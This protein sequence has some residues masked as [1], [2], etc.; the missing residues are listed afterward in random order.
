LKKNSYEIGGIFAPQPSEM[1]GNIHCLSDPN[2]RVLGYISASVV[3]SKRIF[4][5]GKELMM[6]R[7]PFTCSF[8]DVPGSPG[9]VF[10]N[11]DRYTIG[12]RVA[13]VGMLGGVSWSLEACVDCRY[14]GSKN[15]PSFWPNNHQ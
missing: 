14:Y 4:V 7:A 5:S 12:L 6:Y 2:E 15:K 9:Q 8:Q 13:E 1:Q 10:T 3:V 11:R